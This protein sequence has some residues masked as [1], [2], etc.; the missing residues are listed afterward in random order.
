MA[1]FLEI[2]PD[3]K[4][5]EFRQTYFADQ[6]RCSVAFNIARARKAKGLTQEQLAQ[7]TGL[8]QNQISR[9]EDPE[10]GMTLETLVKVLDG[11]ELVP[12]LSLMPYAM[13]AAF[14]APSSER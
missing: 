13:D 12:R 2:H 1:D 9:A 3:F 7:A 10:S 6:F 8:T 11:L 5:R 4:E 14:P